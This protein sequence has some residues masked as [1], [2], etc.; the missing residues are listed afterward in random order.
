MIKNYNPTHLDALMSVWLD[1]TTKAHPFIPSSYWARNFIVIKKQ[2]IPK[3]T[4]YVYEENGEVYGFISILDS[5]YIGALFV[6]E[7][8]QKK[9]IGK[10]LLDHCKEFYDQLSLN[11]Y[12]KN[13]TAVSFY[14][15]NG[16]GIDKEQNNKDTDEAEYTM[17]WVSDNWMEL[18]T[19]MHF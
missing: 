7:A 19:S 3:S 16:F 4:T 5:E 15:K 6:S 2:F 18:L 9:G 13:K 8:K 11:V 14:E 17:S 1:T 12:V 10:A